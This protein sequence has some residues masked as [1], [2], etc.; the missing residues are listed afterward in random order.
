MLKSRT[1]AYDGRGNYHVK[2]VSDVRAALDTLK[3]RH[4]YAEQWANCTTELAVMVVK[5]VSD[6]AQ[7]W[8]EATM[9]Y[10]VVEYYP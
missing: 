2:A 7:N 10:P 4:L 8:Q 3:G 1:E 6:N 5:V 9:A